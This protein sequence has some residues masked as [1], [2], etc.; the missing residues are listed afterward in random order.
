MR[1][2]EFL[3]PKLVLRLFATLLIAATDM[4]AVIR[5]IVLFIAVFVNAAL[6]H[7]HQQFTSVRL[8]Q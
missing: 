4:V 2:Y 8:L 3:I 5:Y 7:A 6:I 1:S